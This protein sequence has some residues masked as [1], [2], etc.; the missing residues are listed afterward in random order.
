MAN[1]TPLPYSTGPAS[2]TQARDAR[3]SQ[4]QKPLQ[5]LNVNDSD[6]ALDTSSDTKSSE[7]ANERSD[8]ERKQDG[9]EAQN[10]ESCLELCRLSKRRSDVERLLKAVVD[11][12]EDFDDSL[13][14]VNTAVLEIASLERL[15]G[16]EA[17]RGRD[18]LHCTQENASPGTEERLLSDIRDELRFC[19]T[20][21]DVRQTEAESAFKCYQMTAE[22]HG[23]YDVYDVWN[24]RAGEENENSE[25]VAWSNTKMNADN[26]NKVTEREHLHTWQRRLYKAVSDAVAKL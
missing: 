13:I 9:K 7:I 5:A 20:A 15:L 16:C 4:S 22:A 26:I 25:F 8:S 11:I 17:K 12:R 18:V 3:K 6:V 23:V 14:V 1:P 19:K 21:V 2:A 24:E 10:E